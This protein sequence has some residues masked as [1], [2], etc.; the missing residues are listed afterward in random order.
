MFGRTLQHVLLLLAV[1]GLTFFTRLGTPAL[2]DRDEPRNA[3][4]AREM[5]QRGDWVVPTFNGELRTQKPV[6]LYWLMMP[7]YRIFGDPEFAARFWSAALGMGTVLMTYGIGRR[8]FNATV[9]LWAGIVLSTTILFPLVARAATP[10]SLFVFC[11]TAAKFV[12]VMGSFP[13]NESTDVDAAETR[14]FPSWPVA[15]LMYAFVGLAVLA[16]GPAGLVLPTATVGMFLLI[17]RLPASAPPAATRLRAIGRA[18]GRVFAPGHFFRTAWFMRP[19]TALLVVSAVALPWYILVWQRTDGVWV[20][21]FLG[22]HNFGRA[23]RPME[24]HGGGEWAY[25]L[26]V[27]LFYPL[28][29][30]VMFFPWSVLAAPVGIDLA[31][32]LR[33]RPRS[34]SHARYLFVTCWAAVYVGIFSVA[35]TKLPTYLAPMYPA[36][37]L[38]AGA[39]LHHWIKRQSLAPARAVLDGMGGLAVV[40]AGMLVALPIVAWWVLRAEM[41]AGAVG[42]IPVAGGLI[43]LRLAKQ[44]RLTGAAR[45]LAVTATAGAVA[46]FAVL[47]VRVDRYQHSHALLRAI[48]ARSDHPHIA[49]YAKLE[50]SWVFYFGQMLKEYKD[51]RPAGELLREDADAFVITSDDKF[52]ELKSSLPDG[53][54]VLAT[55]PYL[56]RTGSLLVIGRTGDLEVA[57]VSV[58]SATE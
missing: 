45:A 34:P 58:R 28:S 7:A 40:G 52:R 15:G 20:K 26:M 30:L 21:V 38:M 9:G 53:V 17:M 54:G 47:V 22:E 49:T 16:K 55:V 56:G 14:Y 23:I 1:S 35:R 33:E 36:L 13:S 41:W 19:I 50:P 29:I 31:K 39:F 37:A 48:R 8:L 46:I 10:E 5:L 2:W 18:I 57:K 12:Y 4:C 44:D 43:A 6:L 3:G 24:G 51:P 27:L 25:P 42:L 11:L 32:R